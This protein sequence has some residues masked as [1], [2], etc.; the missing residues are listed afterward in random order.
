MCGRPTPFGLFSGCS[1]GRV[2]PGEGRTTLSLA[3]VRE[4]KLSSRLDFSYLFALTTALRHDSAIAGRLCYRPN[5]SLHHVAG[6]WHY[7]ESRLT[8][9]SR[10]HHAVKV[11]SDPYLEAVLRSATNGIA[12]ADAVEAV[13]RVPGG[14]EV[15]EEEALAYVQ[16]LI[17]NEL[18]ISDLTP[19][20]TGGPPL[21]ELVGQLES[22]AP[23]AKATQ[24]VART[25]H[26]LDQLNR[27]GLAADT[28]EY[29]AI[30]A[31]LEE[32]PAPI[33]P[34][35]LFQVDLHKPVE[36]VV[37]SNIVANEIRRGI[38]IMCRLHAMSESPLLTTFRRAFVERYGEARVPLLE[39]LDTEG[40]V[41]FGNS[42][43]D[44]S[45]LL[46]GLRLA[47][48]AGPNVQTFC[49]SHSTL[50]KAII[51]AAAEGKTEVQLDESTLTTA[52]TSDSRLPNSF[53]VTVALSA[54][55]AE[56][57][58]KGE[59]DLRF[60]G[61]V[62]PDGARLLGRFCH[63]DRQ[64]EAEVAAY[65][66]QEESHD[67]DAI[68]AEVVY[69]PE[70]RLGNVLCRPVLRTHELVYLGRSGAPA[71]NQIPASDLL[72]AVE[73]E[74]IVLYSQRLGRRVIP[75]LS[76]AHGFMNEN[77]A[78]VYRFL[79][80]LQHQHGV[81][82]F[83][84]S[85]GPFEELPFLPGLRAGRIVLAPPR[86][87]LQRDELTKLGKHEGV[88]RFVAAQELRRR[89]RL[90]RW[91]MI[92]DSDQMLPIDL[93]N[94]LAVD[95]MVHLFNRGMPGHL[96][97]M[98]LSP[99][100][101]CVSGPEGNFV[102]EMTIPMK[103]AISTRNPAPRRSTHRGPALS[104]GD[105][106]RIAPGNDWIFAK[107]YAGGAAIDEILTDF[108]SP[109]IVDFL[110]SGSVSQWFFLRYADP[111]PHLRIRLHG[112][113]LRLRSQAQPLLQDVFSRAL[114]S[115]MT[116]KVQYDTYEREMERYGG[117]DAIG[118]AEEIFF[119][120]SQACLDILH[121]FGGDRGLDLR[122]RT[123]LLGVHLLL[124]DFEFTIQDRYNAMERLRQ[125]YEREFGI[126][127][128][129][130]RA[131]S[132][133]FREYQSDLRAMIESRKPMKFA[134][135]AFTRRSGHVA[136]AVARLRELESAGKLTRGLGDLALSHIHMHVNRMVRSAPRM[137]EL[138]IYTFLARIY[139]SQ[140]ARES[141]AARLKLGTLQESQS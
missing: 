59:F 4:Y 106:R 92:G 40:G 2:Q 24:I 26:R 29:G 17:D 111:H 136:S 94:P 138:L 45:P 7:V 117:S 83:A 87:R 102:H 9:V 11:E 64:L 69:L 21:E 99:D 48:P 133:R 54:S 63:A 116:W 141:A 123:A 66:R 16:E 85:W 10:T 19:L 55:S 81:N 139:D 14:L 68:F 28:A 34:A 35:S 97:G 27:R 32:L 93:E 30:A 75:R 135:R 42:V 13:R 79:C 95:T 100:R 88:S 90:P 57:I 109:L 134:D 121:Q 107:L 53:S 22:V 98:F 82:T 51:Q 110:S 91:V 70:G 104:P 41:G 46:R 129:S 101:L 65:L 127:E 37:L 89:H 43:H 1:L 140:L 115:G 62:G 103:R 84:F 33:D 15:T 130:R 47:G 120:D 3:P 25:A 114:A 124:N 61:A 6:A 23:D 80:Y 12:I 76:N 126:T 105:S 8:G 86:W 131:L 49:P 44:C 50:L 125:A 52:D 119:A 60:V 132:D 113:P 122:W 74:D 31:E 58:D 77:M 71:E 20:V 73:G 72:V 112:D 108:V 78:P 39:A 96:S 67:P 36:S 18:L 128:R 38:S 56:A 137:H 118:A 5:S